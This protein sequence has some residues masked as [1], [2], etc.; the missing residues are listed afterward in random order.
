MKK[1][2]GIEKNKEIAQTNYET[3]YKD[4]DVIINTRSAVLNMTIFYYP[5]CKDGNGLVRRQITN[6]T[7]FGLELFY[8]QNGENAIEL[9]PG[10]LVRV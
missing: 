4:F 10:D 1:G 8:E 5:I 7:V 2:T 6:H 3:V 9:R